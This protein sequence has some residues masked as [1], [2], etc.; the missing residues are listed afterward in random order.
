MEAIRNF[1]QIFYSIWF[2]IGGIY[3]LAKAIALFVKF[4][5]G[6]SDDKDFR[7]FVWWQT[8]SMILLH[9]ARTTI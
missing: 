7:D 1:N 9:L 4:L 3:C 5:R 8:M 6:K 2:G